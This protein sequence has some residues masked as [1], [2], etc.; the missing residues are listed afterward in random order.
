MDSERWRRIEDLCHH[1]LERDPA[2]RASFLED[3]CADDHD[4]RKEVESLLAGESQANSF[5]EVPALELAG[6]A[7]AHQQTQCFEETHANGNDAPSIGQTIS[8]YRIVEKLGGGGMGVVY[9][10]QDLSLARFVALKFLPEDMARD[11]HALERFRREARAASALNHHNICTVHEIGG[12]EHRSFIVME[13]LDGMTLKHVIAGQPMKLEQFLALAIE[14][15]DA[16]DAAHAQGIIHRDIKPANIFVTSRGIAKILDFGV[17]KIM[18]SA[19]HALQVMASSNVGNS[20]DNLT[21]TGSAIGTVAYMSPEQVRGEE[22]DARTDLFSFGAV[23]Y[24]MVTGKMAFGGATTGVISDAILNRDPESPAKFRPTLPVRVED[25]INKALEKDR[26]VRCQSAAEIRADLRRLKREIES[27]TNRPVIRPSNTRWS[28]R[29]MAFAGIGLLALF[30]LLWIALDWLALRHEPFHRVEIRQL[31][32]SGRVTRATISPDGKY[33][34]YIKSDFAAQLWETAPRESLWLRQIVG[35]DVQVIAAA[36]VSYEAPTFSR[37]GDFLYVVRFENGSDTGTLYRTPTLGGA[38][39]RLTTGVDS[40]VSF[41]P[42]QRQVAF[43]RN[44]HHRVI[45]KLGSGGMGGVYSQARNQSALIVRS[46]TGEERQI[47]SQALPDNFYSVAWSPDG[48]TIAATVMRYSENGAYTELVE[49][50]SG[51]GSERKLSSKRWAADYGLTWLPSGE[52]LMVNAQEQPGGESQI[53]FVSRKTGEP[54]SLTSGPNGFQDISATA[55]SGSLATVQS[56]S[57]SDVWVGRIGDSNSFRPIPSSGRPGWARWTLDTKI[58]YGS[59]PIHNSVWTMGQDGSAPKQLFPGAE[60]NVSRFRVSPNGRHVVFFS[61]KG[62]SPHL[63]RMDIDG[64]HWVQL[65]N[66]PNDVNTGLSFTPDGDWVIYNREGSEKGMWKVRV[67]G[68]DAVQLNDIEGYGP[69][70]SPDGLMIA[71]WDNSASSQHSV[72]IAPLAGGS[73]IRTF[74]TPTAS[75][76]ERRWAPDGR[77]FYFVS[78]ENGIS[79]IWKQPVNGYGPQQ[80]TSFNTE[81][82]TSFDLSRDGLQLVLT[83][84]HTSS[85]AVLIRD[86]R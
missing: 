26:E 74:D 70:V 52:G 32:E 12:F 62:N 6:K 10:A 50:P 75:R 77:A 81:Q 21:N 37:D 22:L 17:A 19:R 57:T 45:E 58:I 67:E 59:Y 25:I 83:R 35:G 42:D 48:M 71:Y 36:A 1:A 68:G 82:I 16:L 63:W 31:T 53:V 18:P 30:S 11:P 20:T 9:K 5:L 2:E 28:S 56:N 14:I 43:V 44:S 60:Y 8:H 51:G 84:D 40:S 34:A 64:D 27:G 39:E 61:W 69:E 7:V 33:V 72:V 85:D 29:S 13:F 73:P 47:A 41:S 54:R 4:L 23:L 49:V 3:A 79:N 65:T 76:F 66:S 86:A 46:E 38:L 24:E 80:I 15:C 55:D 78:D